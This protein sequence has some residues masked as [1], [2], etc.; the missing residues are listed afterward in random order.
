MKKDW[1]MAFGMLMILLGIGSICLSLF[2][3]TFPLL[4]F[5]LLLIVM[6]ITQLIHATSLGDWKRISTALLLGLLY[7]VAGFFLL[8]KPSTAPQKIIFWTAL[9]CFAV[10]VFRMLSS[11]LQH[12]DQK[13]WTFF[14]GAVT[15]ILGLI[16]LTGWPVSGFWII[17]VIIGIDMILSGWS[18]ALRA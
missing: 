6:G 11:L 9:F 5:S 8:I 1:N 17:G 10:G 3:A 14:N 4:P 15:F 2:S 16:L 12:F 18:K 7:L 13:K